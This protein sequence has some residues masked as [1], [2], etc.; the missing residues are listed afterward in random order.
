MNPWW[1]PWPLN[2]DNE[3][4]PLGRS[5]WDMAALMQHQQR[6]LTEWTEAN[7][8]WLSWWMSTLPPLPGT[9]AF[10]HQDTDTGKDRQ[11]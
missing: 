6:L 4:T 3:D 11:P 9:P 10:K 5:P 8:I 2:L 7:Q 1:T